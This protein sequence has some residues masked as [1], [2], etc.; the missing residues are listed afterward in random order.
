MQT[1]RHNSYNEDPYADEFGIKITEKFASVDAR[2]LPPP[3]VCI[4]YLYVIE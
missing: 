4:I 1:V 2:I 3:W